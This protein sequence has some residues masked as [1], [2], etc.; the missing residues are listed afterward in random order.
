MADEA[1]ELLMEIT[2]AGNKDAQDTLAE[3]IKLVDRDGKVGGWV[4]G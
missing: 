3:H 2:N 4:G 1:L